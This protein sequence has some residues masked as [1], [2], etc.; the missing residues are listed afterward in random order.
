M[1]EILK[2]V[3]KE[4]DNDEK[5]LEVE[6]L[7]GAGDYIDNEPVFPMILNAI[8]AIEELTKSKEKFKTMQTKQNIINIVK[9]NEYFDDCNTVYNKISCL[10]FHVICQ[11]QITN[12]QS[13]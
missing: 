12:K 4:S 7:L 2:E 3:K 1:C 10:V 5:V 9:T 11:T 8:D 13:V 6:K